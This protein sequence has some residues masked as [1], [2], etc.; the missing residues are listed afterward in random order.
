MCR[1]PESCLPRSG[2]VPKAWSLCSTG[3]LERWAERGQVRIGG[4][5]VED[6]KE[7]EADG[8]RGREVSMPTKVARDVL[9]GA[10]RIDKI[11]PSRFE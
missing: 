7:E 10:W 1:E 11:R 5:A 2:R 6:F 3:L 9:P 8:Y 4:A